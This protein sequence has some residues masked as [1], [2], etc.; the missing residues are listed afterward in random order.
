MNSEEIKVSLWDLLHRKRIKVTPAGMLPSYIQI[1]IEV[2]GKPNIK[3]SGNN[4]IINPASKDEIKIT[5]HG[6]PGE[7]ILTKKDIKGIE[8]KKIFRE[9]FDW[10][11]ICFYIFADWPAEEDKPPKPAKKEQLKLF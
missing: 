6:D 11:T 7:I 9:P 8:R 4:M 3:F 10:S 2:G 1:E 5:V